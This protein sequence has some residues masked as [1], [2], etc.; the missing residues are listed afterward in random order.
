MQGRGA[1]WRASAAY[2]EV[3]TFGQAGMCLSASM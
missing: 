2:M 3:L 1:S